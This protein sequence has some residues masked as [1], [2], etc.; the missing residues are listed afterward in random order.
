MNKTE[1]CFPRKE[2]VYLKVGMCRPDNK[3]DIYV[4]KIKNKNS[5]INLLPDFRDIN[6][7]YTWNISL[8]RE[9]K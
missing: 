2:H 4:Q 5:V 3:R 7:F 9:K 6:N 8:D 1:I